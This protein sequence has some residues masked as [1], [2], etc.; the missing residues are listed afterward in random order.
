MKGNKLLRALSF[1]MAVLMLVSAVPLESYAAVSHAEAHTHNGNNGA[2]EM[3]EESVVIEEII[4]EETPSGLPYVQQRVEEIMTAYLGG[5]DFTQ[6]EVAAAVSAMDDDAYIE[7]LS[8]LMMLFESEEMAAL[9][10]A[11]AAALDASYPALGAFYAALYARYEVDYADVS[12]YATASVC[13]GVSVDLK[14]GE[15]GSGKTGGYTGVTANN[16][17]VDIPKVY[18][19]SWSFLDYTYQF[20]VNFETSG[21]SKLKFDYKMTLGGAPKTFTIDGKNADRKSVV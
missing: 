6:E 1:L 16:G 9:T 12:V 10:D 4:I 3:A 13:D 14:T 2:S 7:A 18:S 21:P 5:T 11:E 15:G 20:T 8:E 17:V 19:G